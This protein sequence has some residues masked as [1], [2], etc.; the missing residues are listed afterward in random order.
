M[1]QA[2]LVMFLVLSGAGSVYASAEHSYYL[3]KDSV[4]ISNC[5]GLNVAVHIDKID[6][7]GHHVILQVPGQSPRAVTIKNHE[8][9]YFVNKSSPE[10]NYTLTEKIDFRVTDKNIMTHS[11]VQYAGNGKDLKECRVTADYHA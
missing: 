7:D 9:S 11:L 4:N 1:Q 10:K 8:G 6:Y 5:K 2:R 3:N